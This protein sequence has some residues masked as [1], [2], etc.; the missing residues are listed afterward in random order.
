[1]TKCFVRFNHFVIR[2]TCGGRQRRISE[3]GGYSVK[4]CDGTGTGVG[5]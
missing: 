3:F 1:M 5:L 4:S 2:R